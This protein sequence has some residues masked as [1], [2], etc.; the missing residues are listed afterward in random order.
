LQDVFV[1]SRKANGGCSFKT[2]A[3]VIQNGSIGR[4]G[5]CG[6]ARCYLPVFFGSNIFVVLILFIIINNILR[7][8]IRFIIR[9]IGV[10]LARAVGIAMVMFA[11]MM[12][13]TVSVLSILQKREHMRIA[14]QQKG[15]KTQ[16]KYG[17]S[18]SGTKATTRKETEY[19][20]IQI[21]W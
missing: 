9:N 14:L 6:M 10:V 19:K 20:L 7:F 3:E 5:M 12:Y 13:M 1:R 2:I 21:V 4:I 8:P 17:Y 15:T 18:H 16:K 11:G